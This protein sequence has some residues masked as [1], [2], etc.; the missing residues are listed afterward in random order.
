MARKNN[1]SQ[2][3]PEKSSLNDVERD[4]RMNTTPVRDE[5]ARVERTSGTPTFPVANWYKFR[6]LKIS[7]V[8]FRTGR[9]K[10]GEEYIDPEHYEAIFEE[11]RSGER[12][13]H[14]IKMEKIDSFLGGINRRSD[15]DFSSK[16]RTWGTTYKQV[17]ETKTEDDKG[18]SPDVQKL[19]WAQ[20]YLKSYPINIW[21][22][23]TEWIDQESGQM[24][25]SKKP[26]LIFWVKSDF[27]DKTK[28]TD[29]PLDF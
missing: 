3:T 28:K 2:N 5:D 10:F 16:L 12:I 11:L 13:V 26:Q 18:R 23:Y 8:D 22:D 29:I 1:L 9:N 7:Y 17:I 6:L 25:R 27:E 19:M 15:Y 21:Y 24:H 14:R 20:K 4:N